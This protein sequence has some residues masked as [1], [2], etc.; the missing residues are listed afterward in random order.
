MP[1]LFDI[2][3]LPFRFLD[4][5]DI[6]LVSVMFYLLY[7]LVRGTIALNIF[8]GIMSVFMFWWL[9]RAL[10]MRLLT[11]I[12]GQFIEVG[13]LALLIVFQQEIRRFLL[14]IGRNS[15]RYRDRIK[16][17][18]LMP[19]NWELDQGRQLNS[20]ELV[21]ACFEMADSYTGALI[22]LSKDSDLRSYTNTGIEIRARVKKP[23][24]I[25]I[26]Q[27]NSPL[28]DGAV[29]IANNMIVATSC[30]LPVSQSTD[31]P[32][33]YGLRHRSAIGLTEQTDAVAIIVS[34]ESG[35]VSVAQEGDIQSN[36]SRDT[37]LKLIDTEI[38][39]ENT[40]S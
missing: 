6:L 8:I 26:F 7:R 16:W 29:I 38:I 11:G 28:H 13:V 21:N 12:L 18:D 39:G 31:I 19:W 25:A 17:T 37:L 35:W 40:D 32:R 36:I 24:L 34:E 10:N 15:L 27:K 1:L 9:V 33:H 23:L 20:Q 4:F 22:V 2:G 14:I 3:F 30:I 5:L